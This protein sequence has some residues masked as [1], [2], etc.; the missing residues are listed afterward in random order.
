MT[1]RAAALLGAFLAGACSTEGPLAPS[2]PTAQPVRPVTVLLAFDDA[3]G[4]RAHR[5]TAAEIEAAAP[6]LVRFEFVPAGAG[7]TSVIDAET[8]ASVG[9][10]AAASGDVRSGRLFF[11]SLYWAGRRPVVT[12]E[13]LHL[14]GFQHTGNRDDIMCSRE[15]SADG[16]DGD[17]NRTMSVLE[18]EE[19]RRRLSSASAMS[20]SP[21]RPVRCDLR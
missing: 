20:V 15:L 8:P 9:G 12:H 13:M 2:V 10:V 19:L 14:F 3:A 1:R 4:A 6:G 11:S 21:A 5:E 17:P 7:V 16:C 18:K